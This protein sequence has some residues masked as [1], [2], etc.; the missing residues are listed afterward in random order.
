MQTNKLARLALRPK[1]FHTL[2]G[3]TPCQ[4]IK[5]LADLRPIWEAAEIKRKSRPGRKRAIG[6]GPKPKLDLSGDLFM[7]LL[8]YRTYAGQVF[9][10]TVVGL[11]D[12]NVSR[13]IRRLEP[14]LQRVFRV[15]AK[16]IDLTENEIW[17]LIVDATEQ[18]TERRR[19]TKFSGKKYRQ[20]IKTQI[21]V[22]KRGIIRSVSKS[23]TGNRHDKHLYDITQA[24]CRGP[25]G[26]PMRVKTKSDLGYVGT[27]CDTPIKKP[28]SRPLMM[29]EEYA[30]KQHTRQRIG[31]EHEIAHIKQ[32]AVIGQ[33]FRH[34]PNRHNLMFRNVAGLRNLIR[35]SVA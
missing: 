4:F 23:T 17:E 32:W 33:R 9:I 5:L 12:S 31:V 34:T 20:T 30:N 24:Y 18:E 16:R 1:I 21:H 19:G 6:Q 3:L 25:D 8:F 13:R 15:P 11:D 26:K 35:T 10:G 28:K 7:L 22:D 29:H 14:L 2:I 27:A